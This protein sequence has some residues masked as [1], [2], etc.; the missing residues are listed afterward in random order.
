[1]ADLTLFAIG[2]KRMTWLSTRQAAIAGNV[3]NVDTPGFRARDVAPF[4]SYHDNSRLDMV[5][6]PPG[7][8]RVEGGNEFEV[9][10]SQSASGDVKH[11]G[12]NVSLEHEMLRAGEVR[13]AHRVATSVVGAFHGM[14]L[15]AVKG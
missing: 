2:A 3:A 11:S 4:D 5:A 14:L 12:N 7:H 13:G 15:S 6:T 8:I 10:V 1:M 9:E